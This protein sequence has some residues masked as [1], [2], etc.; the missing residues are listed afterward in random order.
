MGGEAFED[1]PGRR[2][3]AAVAAFERPGDRSFDRALPRGI[4]PHAPLG[5]AQHRT[6][7]IARVVGTGQQPVPNEP[8]EHPGQ[9]ARMHVQDGRQIASRHAWEQTDHPQHQPLRA[10]D[11]D[12]SGHSLRHSFQSV[13]DGP[14]QLHELEYIGEI[15]QHLGPGDG[16]RLRHIILNSN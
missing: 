5:E 11:A 10:R 15:G 1:A 2:P 14:E 7:S 4:D 9:R 8:L 12:V 16:V 13:H 6:S 3:I